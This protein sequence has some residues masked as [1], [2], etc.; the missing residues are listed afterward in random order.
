MEHLAYTYA[1]LVEDCER[2]VDE[3]GCATVRVRGLHG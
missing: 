3:V 1:T 2:V